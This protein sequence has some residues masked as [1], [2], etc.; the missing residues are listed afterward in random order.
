VV[1]A[2]AEKAVEQL[3]PP[4]PLE[5]V[6]FGVRHTLLA[7]DPAR[8]RDVEPSPDGGLIADFLGAVG[9]PRELSA[10][11]SATAGVVEHGLFAPELVSL[12]IIAGEDA[13]QRRAGGKPESC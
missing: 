11:L 13:V 10:R 7:L 1:I 12:I 5:L 3:T 2:S 4:V 6:A 8:L 9:D